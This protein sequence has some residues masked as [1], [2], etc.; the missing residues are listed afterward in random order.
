M[1]AASSRGGGVRS[2]AGRSLPER[3][4]SAFEQSRERASVA[5]RDAPRCARRLHET[6]LSRARYT[7]PHV[8][9]T[10]YERR[11]LLQTPSE[12]SRHLLSEA[13]LLASLERSSRQ[14]RHEQ[15]KERQRKAVRAVLRQQQEEDR[16]RRRPPVVGPLVTYV[17][18]GAKGAAMGGGIDGRMTTGAGLPTVA[19]P[20]GIGWL[21]PRITPRL[22]QGMG[23]ETRQAAAVE[24]IEPAS[25]GVMMHRAEVE[26]ADE[27]AKA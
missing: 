27:E 14:Q 8:R 22:A 21:A 3:A 1:R 23:E 12:G 9:P 13:E 26:G 6:P 2:E 24:A 11:W 5:Q 7:T 4:S 25:G 16:N 10:L 20:E 19:F 17:V 18:G 15:E